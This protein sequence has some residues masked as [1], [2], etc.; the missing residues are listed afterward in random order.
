MTASLLTGST[1]TGSVVDNYGVST[2]GPVSQTFNATDIQF[3]VYKPGFVNNT[4]QTS[5][6][7]GSAGGG[8]QSGLAN[9]NKVFSNTTTVI[10][11]DHV[12]NHSIKIPFEPNTLQ[13]FVEFGNTGWST[14]TTWSKASG[15]RTINGQTNVVYYTVT[16]TGAA[17][18][19]VDV[20]LLA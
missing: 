4:K 13:I 14:Q 11:V 9:T 18:S 19:Q 16:W 5:T 20:K 12:Y 6:A 17:R 7:A 8:G 2:N 10:V 3:N 15:T 1:S